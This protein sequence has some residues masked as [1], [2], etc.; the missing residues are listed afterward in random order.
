MLSTDTSLSFFSSLREQTETSSGGSCA[1][2]PLKSS[3]LIWSV[4]AVVLAQ[5]CL[6]RAAQLSQW[7]SS[8][9]YYYSSDWRESVSSWGLASFMTTCTS[10]RQ[11]YFQRILSG[12]QHMYI[13]AYG[14]I[15]I[16]NIFILLSKN[17]TR[18]SELLNFM[19]FFRQMLPVSLM[20][21]SR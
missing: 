8:P 15:L 1:S 5:C 10:F 19:F 21:L 9:L 11:R 14:C 6:D 17:K 20:H 12:P 4:S 16:F 18:W 2:I 13:D 3:T 7:F